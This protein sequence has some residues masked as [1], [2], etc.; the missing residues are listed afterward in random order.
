MHQFQRLFSFSNPVLLFSKLLNIIFWVSGNCFYFLFDNYRCLV[1]QLT[2]KYYAVQVF[3]LLVIYSPSNFSNTPEFCSLICVMWWA[4]LFTPLMC[5]I[6]VKLQ[7]CETVQ[8]IIVRISHIWTRQKVFSSSDIFK[9]YTYFVAW[10][11]KFR[12]RGQRNGQ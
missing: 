3:S 4:L 10:P 11:K 5:A 8:H 2:L 12:I 7:H 6:F 1:W 9:G